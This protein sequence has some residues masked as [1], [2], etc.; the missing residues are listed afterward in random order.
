MYR[1]AGEGPKV[2]TAANA[3]AA[4][5]SLTPASAS[6]TRSSASLTSV[7]VTTRSRRRTSVLDRQRQQL[8]AGRADLYG[9]V[10]LRAG[11]F[12]H[13]HL[14]RAEGG[15][16]TPVTACIVPSA[17][18]PRVAIGYHA[19]SAISLGSCELLRPVRT[20]TWANGERAAPSDSAAFTVVPRCSP[21]VLVR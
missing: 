16:P 3:A 6:I 1:L 14:C 8:L 20:L 11:S 12:P 9:R 5:S 7:R 17:G 18:V 13:P 4:S 15:R 2:P 21:L 10:H 19:L